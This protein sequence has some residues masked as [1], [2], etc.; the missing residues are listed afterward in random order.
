MLKKSKKNCDAVF[1][2]I[3]GSFQMRT[4]HAVEHNKYRTNM[5]PYVC[6]CNPPWYRLHNMA[7]RLPTML[8][9]GVVSIAGVSYSLS[10]A[11]D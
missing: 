7:C 6:S 4:Q 1:T 2:P 3:E 8:Q 9:L 10:T 5:H 11:L